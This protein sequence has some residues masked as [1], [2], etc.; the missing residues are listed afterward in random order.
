MAVVVDTDVVSFLFKEDTRTPLYTSHLV[1]VAALALYFDIPLVTNNR[2]H[3]QNVKN[4]K[5]ISES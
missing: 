5:I 3:F 4:L 1:W 2:R